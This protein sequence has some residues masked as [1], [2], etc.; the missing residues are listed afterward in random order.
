MMIGAQMFRATQKTKVYPFGCNSA[1]AKNGNKKG[2][3]TPARV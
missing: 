2:T 3:G 1:M